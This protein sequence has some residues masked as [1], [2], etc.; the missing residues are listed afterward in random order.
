MASSSNAGI[1][2]AVL[3]PVLVEGTDGSLVEPSG[4][5][6]KNFVASLALAKSAP[7]SATALIDDLW[8]DDPPRQAKAALQTLVSRVRSECAH[9]LIESR[10]GGYALVAGA[11]GTD[12]DRAI[13]YRDAARTSASKGNH[14]DVA[15]QATAGL[16]LWRGEPG[17]DVN[18]DLAADL[19]ARAD[20][21]RA[22]LRHLR[23]ESMIEL[24]RA[25]DVVGEVEGLAAALPLD[26]GLQLLLLR[27]LAA[28]GRRKDAIAAFARYR[29]L[30]RDELGTSPSEKLVQVNAALLRED[31]PAVR[32]NDAAPSDETP[33]RVARV[34]IGLRT[35][36][37]QLLGRERDLAALEELMNSSRLTTILGIGGLGKTRLAL[38]LGQ[39]ASETTPAVVVVELAS[40]R[41]GDDVTLAL[42]S[43]LGIREVNGSGRALSDPG[44]RLDVRE[45]ILSVLGERQTLLIVDNCEHIVDAAAAWIGDILASTTN[46]RILATSRSPLAISGESVYQLDSLASGDDN[47]QSGPA[48]RLFMERAE[49]ARPSVSLP[50]DIIARLCTRLDGLP[51]AIELAAARVRSMSVEE[52]ERRLS[53]RFTLLTSGERT[54]PERH[55]TLMAVIDWSWNLLN[56]DERK[57]LRRLSRFPD[58]FSAD[59]ALIVGADDDNADITDALDGLVNQS[60]VAATETRVPGLL[61]YRMLETVREFGEV[62]LVDAGEDAR[63]RAAMA[64]WAH[65]FCAR[66]LPQLES[67]DQVRAFQ[68]VASEQDNLVA[69]LR[70]ALADE[71]ADAVV[72]VFAALA[73]HWSM[74]GGHSDVA[75]FG[76]AILRATK[77][78]VPDASHLTAAITTFAI[79]S[80]SIMFGDA[81]TG[82]VGRGR[83]RTVK[84][85]GPASIPR[86]DVIAE[87]ILAVS[88]PPKAMALLDRYQ[89]STDEGLVA[90]SSLI[91][92]QLHENAGELE[93]AIASSRRAFEVA[94]PLGDVWL[95]ST[96]AQGLANLH[97]QQGD[98]VRALEWAEKSRQGLSALQANGDLQQLSWLI[99]LNQLPTTPDAAR[100]TFDAFV[101][102][103]DQ[104]LGFDYLD[105]RSIGWAGLAEIALGEGRA[106]QGR[107]FYRNAVNAFHYSRGRM[108]PWN[109]IA[110]T[111]CLC[112]YVFTDSTE[113]LYIDGL[114]RR[115]RSKLLATRRVMQV[116]TDMPVAGTAVVG[117]STWILSPRRVASA[118]AREIGLRLLFLGEAMGG[119]QDLPS[120]NRN[121]LT[122]IA[123]S[124][125]G[126][127]AVDEARASVAGL[128]P[129]DALDL[130][131]E[132]LTSAE[133][134][135]LVSA[136]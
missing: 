121:R 75:G 100:A 40:V 102:E 16:S 55:R 99:A 7:R 113:Q 84:E 57:L 78:Y 28:A 94:G 77:H 46:V 50:V 70:E 48:I 104:A 69:V 126:A 30:L 38:E 85:L 18:A 15:A 45:R 42:G 62:A 87:L 3:G 24:G 67:M 60:L 111:G 96:A 10:N 35:A 36:P 71:N 109:T 117:L 103:G 68:I 27:A 134:R 106:E 132:L 25:A 23:A 52:I 118:A 65:A 29:A 86:I 93:N 88:D 73:Y 56:E 58:G 130:A 22:E 41:S 47:G 53:H 120:L 112:A 2:V 64:A 19:R 79:V 61:R 12:L 8:G 39:R 119:R 59:A 32:Q 107:E 82:I 17:S 1:R 21:L 90:L 114:A 44:V 6:G 92:A 14:T 74:R 26:E 54:A 76:K 125:Q 51:L 110:T 43:T 37:N 72:T 81:R 129:M 80:V 5:L 98:T 95:Q 4:T 135:G 11:E 116:I 66:M 33:V 13:H 49:A 122:D 105:L 136:R 115:I 89:K 34:R 9:G 31:D 20:P 101:A 133:V 91:V 83:L 97:S 128:S 124:T 63:V 108:A 127:A 123:I 131:C